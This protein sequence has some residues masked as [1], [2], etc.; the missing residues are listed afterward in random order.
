[1]AT[2]DTNTTINIDQA[3]KTNTA[4]IACTNTKVDSSGTIKNISE[5]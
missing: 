4:F 2:S 5:C 1:M 3:V